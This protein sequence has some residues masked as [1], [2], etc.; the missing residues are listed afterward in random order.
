MTARRSTPRPCS[1]T[2]PFPVPSGA[3]R[4]VYAELNHYLLN[5]ICP[6]GLGSPQAPA[7]A[8]SEGPG[9]PDGLRL[10]FERRVLG[11]VR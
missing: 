5:M 2:P 10:E 6:P 4:Y 7:S 3:R 9:E 11:G 1:S 8:G